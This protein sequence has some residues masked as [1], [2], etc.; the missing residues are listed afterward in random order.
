M[1]SSDLAQPQAVYLREDQ[2]IAMWVA[3]REHLAVVVAREDGD[4]HSAYEELQAVR[5]IFGLL[6][7]IVGE[8]LMYIHIY[9]G[10]ASCDRMNRWTLPA[11]IR[12]KLLPFY[13]SDHLLYIYIYI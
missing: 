3:R 1:N 11:R 8:R 12:S 9:R 5:A 4:V 2:A 10:N 7:Y 13:I 6:T